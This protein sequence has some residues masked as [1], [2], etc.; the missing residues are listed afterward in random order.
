MA[1]RVFAGTALYDAVLNRMNIT[2]EPDAKAEDKILDAMDAAQTLLRSYA[3]D[4]TL[5][6]GCS[7]WSDLFI[8]CSW[9]LA[10]N[11]RA[12]F[13]ADYGSEL[14]QLRMMEGFGCGKEAED[15]V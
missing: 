5:D 8:V 2:W 12:D 13:L 15:S 10:E 4:Y 6:F 11:K 1:N 7:E 3:G 9:Y 14:I